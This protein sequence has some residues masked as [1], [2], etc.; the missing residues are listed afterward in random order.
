MSDSELAFALQERIA[1]LEAENERINELYEYA[2]ESRKRLNA[3]N[4]RLAEEL[5]RLPYLANTQYRTFLCS[6]QSAL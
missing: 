2:L 1:E 5:E 3:E 4:L 6:L